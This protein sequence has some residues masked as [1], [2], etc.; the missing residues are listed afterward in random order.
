MEQLKRNPNSQF[1]VKEITGEGRYEGALE[2]K[3]KQ[4]V[5]T[6]AYE[7]PN[8]NSEINDDDYDRFNIGATKQ[9]KTAPMSPSINQ[10][11]ILFEP[12]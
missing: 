8:Y 1:V 7:I 12:R 4:Y 9:Q 11:G 3:L 2:K 10:G 6:G 5:K